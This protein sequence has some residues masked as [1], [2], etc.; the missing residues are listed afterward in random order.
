[1]NGDVE[2]ALAL[3]AV[4]WKRE[5]RYEVSCA[6]AIASAPRWRPRSRRGGGR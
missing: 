1:V 6:R 2:A 4:R 5:A 3:E